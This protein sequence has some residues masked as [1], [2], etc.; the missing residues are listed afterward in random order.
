MA[1]L[2]QEAR[3]YGAAGGKPQVDW[4][5][6]LLASAAVRLFTQLIC[7]WNSQPSGSALL[8][9]DGNKGLLTAIVS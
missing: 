7:P 8:E 5:N 1:K 9:Y 4:P 3:T 6:G 2:V